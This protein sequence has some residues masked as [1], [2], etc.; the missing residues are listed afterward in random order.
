V[1]L[2]EPISFNLL[3]RGETTFQYLYPR[4]EETADQIN[5]AVKYGFSWDMTKK[6]VNS[7]ND[8]AC[9]QKIGAEKRLGLVNSIEGIPQEIQAILDDESHLEDLQR[10]DVP[11][12][13]LCGTK[14]P[15]EIKRITCLLNEEI[16]QARH[17]TIAFAGHLLPITHETEVVGH[18]RDHLDRCVKQEQVFV[19]PAN[20]VVHF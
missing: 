7:W 5:F 14:S 1:V 18:I 4:L 9:W 10:I 2:I 3:P 11:V 19:S 16:E 20:R 8:Q 13:I 6:F 15:D 12:S 17:R